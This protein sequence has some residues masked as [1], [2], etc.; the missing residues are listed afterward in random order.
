MLNKVK[1]TNI[2]H[3]YF[4]HEFLKEGNYQDSIRQKNY[5][6]KTINILY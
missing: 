5:Y 2:N 4:L 3:Y 1:K 6:V